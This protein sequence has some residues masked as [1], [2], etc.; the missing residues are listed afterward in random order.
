MKLSDSNL[1]K[2]KEIVVIVIAASFIAISLLMVGLT[3]PKN[4]WIVMLSGYCS[5]DFVRLGTE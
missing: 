2:G 4:S 5:H 1:M 3:D